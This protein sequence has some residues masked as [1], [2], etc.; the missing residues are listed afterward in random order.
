M[1]WKLFLTSFGVVFLAE[2]GD[3]TQ[4]A[5]L[6]LASG[7]SSRWA[8]FLGSSL[9]LIAASAIAV[10][11]GEALV[12][13]VP[14]LWLQRGAGVLCLAVGAWLVWSPGDTIEGP[15]PAGAATAADPGPDA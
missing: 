6:A 5:T 3:R 12:R 1:D 11:A 10:V 13:V 2:V 14:V 9:A 15:P 7:G 4:L 8:V